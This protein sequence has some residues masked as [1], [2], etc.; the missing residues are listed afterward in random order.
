[1]QSSPFYK[2]ITWENTWEAFLNGINLIHRKSTAF[3]NGINLIHRKSTVLIKVPYKTFYFRTNFPTME[4]K[5]FFWY[6]WKCKEK[7]SFKYL[8]SDFYSFVLCNSFYRKESINFFWV[9]LDQNLTWKERIKLTEN[10]IAK[11]IGIL[12]ESRPY[13][14]K[15]NLTMPLLLIYSLLPKLC[16]YSMMRH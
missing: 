14:D 6:H 10:K 15:K 13:L 9:L 8:A 3:L 11:N 7:V 5:L 1:M 2:K 12:Y 4:R 16:K